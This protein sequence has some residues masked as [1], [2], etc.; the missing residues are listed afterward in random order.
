MK[1]KS[2]ERFVG[3]T[4]MPEYYQY[5]GIDSVIENL[6][7]RAK[8]TA[9]TTSPYVMKESTAE[10]GQREPPIDAGAGKVRL[11]DRPLWGKQELYVET[12]PSFIPDSTLYR[13]ME[14]QPAMPSALTHEHG[15]IVCRFLE[16][17]K[18][19][20]L[21]TY[22]QVQAA[23]PP[24]YRVQFGG[25]SVEDLPRLPD[26]A[27]PSGRVANNASLVSPAIQAYQR[28]LIQDLFSAYP[29]IDGI[30]FDWPEYP[31][32]E[33]DSVFMDFSAHTELFAKEQGIN[34]EGIRDTIH[35]LREHLCG[36]LSSDDLNH[37][38]RA[39]KIIG[40]REAADENG[41]VARCVIDWLNLK[42]AASNDLLQSFRSAM[43]DVGGKNVELVAHAFPPPWSDLSGIDFADPGGIVSHFAVKLYGMHWLM[44][45][46]FYADQIC[47]GCGLA[48]DEGELVEALFE[49]FD[50]DKPSGVQVVSDIRYPDPDQA[51]PGTDA[52]RTRKIR[53]AQAY[54]GSVPVHALEHGYGPVDDFRRRVQVACDA[55]RTQIWLNRYG[56]LSDEKLDIVGQIG[57]CA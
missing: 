14:Y 56:Y 51:H 34:F 36:S 11:L 30:R 18:E 45:L 47:A 37:V 32:Y 31:P 20:G 39:R 42:R 8:A 41:D 57:S 27:S 52:D 16:A 35:G 21:K 3:I 26:G 33:L 10:R 17:A 28:A 13:G 9:V 38:G 54:A 49:F 29:D 43:D 19:S 5:E 1:D 23:I 25:P 48:L 50:V 46:R 7:G 22:L 6:L 24:G 44:M 55:S 12:A 4:V 15:S 2:H 53:Q 40:L